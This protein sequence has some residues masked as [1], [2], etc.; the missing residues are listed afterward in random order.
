MEDDHFPPDEAP[1]LPV[2]SAQS[3]PDAAGQSSPARCRRLPSVSSPQLL[4]FAR[5]TRFDTRCK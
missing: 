5:E 4:G 2:E 1:M 3:R